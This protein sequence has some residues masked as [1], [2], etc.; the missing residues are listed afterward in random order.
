MYCVVVDV[1]IVLV[2][3]LLFGIVVVLYVVECVC[4]MMVE[5][6]YDDVYMFGFDVM[7]M[8]LMCD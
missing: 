6:F 4:W 1:L 3:M 5:W 8:I 2:I 7:M